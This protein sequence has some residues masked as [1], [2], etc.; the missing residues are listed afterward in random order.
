[1]SC[2]DMVEYDFLSALFLCDDIFLQA[3]TKI[4]E[5]VDRRKLSSPDHN[6][7]SL[8]FN[9]HRFRHFYFGSASTCHMESANFFTTEDRT[10][11]NFSCWHSVS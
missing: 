10:F 6:Q 5:S 2:I 11:G 1:M 4:L 3:N 9:Q 8:I 7:Y